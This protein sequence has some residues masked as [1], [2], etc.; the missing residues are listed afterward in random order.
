[1]AEPA[2]ISKSIA[3]RYAVAV[4]DLAK[5]QTALAGLEAD[6]D[7]LEALL[8]DSPEFTAMTTSP[9]VDRD[10]QEAAV[11]A[12]AGPLNLS[13]LMANTLALMAGKR[14]LFVLPYL[15]SELRR[16]LA[17]ERGEVTAEVTA[18]APLND[19]QAE[20]LATVLRQK[21]G[22]EIRINATVDESIIGGLVVKVG[23]QMIDTSIAARLANLKNA[24]KEVG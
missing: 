3:E 15:A 21:F 24:M 10:D 11:K 22:R 17:D 2:S 6:L 19:A 4:F 14:R 12:L 16:M 20:R 18:A 13:P 7:T 8:R 23:S 1:M 5:D 9:R